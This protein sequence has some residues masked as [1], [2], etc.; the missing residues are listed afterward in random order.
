M[1]DG[2][3]WDSILP[4]PSKV[5]LLYLGQKISV[6][7]A[8]AMVPQKVPKEGTCSVSTRIFVTVVEITGF[9]PPAPRLIN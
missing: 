3:N 7:I 1:D 6:V 4:S 5:W 8:V 9:V 2:V